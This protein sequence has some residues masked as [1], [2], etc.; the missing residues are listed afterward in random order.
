MGYDSS[1]PSKELWTLHKRLTMRVFAVKGSSWRK[2]RKIKI[3]CFLRK[4][5]AKTYSFW[6]VYGLSRTGN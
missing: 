2:L 1:I 5:P 3:I 6:K 4:T